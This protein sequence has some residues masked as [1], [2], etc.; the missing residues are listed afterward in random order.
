MDYGG[1]KINTFPKPGAT[2]IYLQ[3]F[4]CAE[5]PHK[6]DTYLNL[7]RKFY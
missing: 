7:Q 2:R 1:Y 3:F 6:I 4:L 5:N